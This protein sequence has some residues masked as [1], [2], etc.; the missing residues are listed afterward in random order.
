MPADVMFDEGLGNRPCLSVVIPVFNERERIGP[1]LERVSAYLEARGFEYEVIVVDDGSG[2]DTPSKVQGVAA[3][4]P[5]V[6]L[7]R[8]EHG[9]KGSAVRQGVLAASKTRVMYCDADLAVPIEE[10]DKLLDEIE[11]GFDIAVGSKNLPRSNVI[12]RPLL[13]DLMGKALNLLVRLFLF[14]G[15]KDTQCGF[16]CFR[17]DVARDLFG[18]LRSR[19]FSFDIELLHRAKING[20]K[21]SEVPVTCMHRGGSTVRPLKDSVAMLTDLCRMIAGRL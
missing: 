11:R 2:D 18:G 3:G 16:K 1:T 9:G 14:S 20:Y 15:I 19:G 13:R 21:I 17:R 7:I 12:G 4:N 6:R 10:V 5:R 8:S